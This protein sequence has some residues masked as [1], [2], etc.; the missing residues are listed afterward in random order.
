MLHAP[1]RFKTGSKVGLIVALTLSPLALAQDSNSSRYD[2]PAQANAQDFIAIF[3]EINGEHPGIR[4]AHARGICAVGE[5]TPSATAKERF[6]TALFAADTVPLT[7]RFSMGGGNPNA[8]ERQG[9]R[10]VGIHF[11]LPN[12]QSHMIAGITSPVFSG[13]TPNHFLG[14]LQWNLKIMRG[15]ATR[16]DLQRYFAAHPSMQPALAW[17]RERTA[18]TEYTTA[19]YYGIHAFWAS[20]VNDDEKFRWQLV[21]VAGEQNLSA[22]QV[23][24]GPSSFLSERLVDRLEQDGKVT[25]EWLWTIGQADDPTHDPSVMWPTDREQVNVGRITLTAAGGDACT[26]VNFDPNRVVRGIRPSDDPVLPIR[27]AAYAIS[28]GQRLSGQ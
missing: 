4:K 15:E 13:A 7:L 9:A 28:F 3:K 20:G 12:N 25:F 21:P 24:S 27:S 16:D 10:G 8:D 26:P 1:F 23:K 14:L 5:F 11:Q 18:S 17:G 19:T 22:E 2:V 6:S